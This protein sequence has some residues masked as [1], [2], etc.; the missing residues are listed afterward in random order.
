MRP[1][2]DS[3]QSTPGGSSPTPSRQSHRSRRPKHPASSTPIA[4][5]PLRGAPISSHSPPTPLTPPP[6]ITPIDEEPSDVAGPSNVSNRYMSPTDL[7]F[8][9]APDLGLPMSPPEERAE[10][11]PEE[12][13]AEATAS[14]LS[15][16]LSSRSRSRSASPGSAAGA[17]LFSIPRR[18][19]QP[20]TH[21]AKRLSN[22][23]TELIR[24]EEEGPPA[25]ELTIQVH[26]PTPESPSTPNPP[27]PNQRDIHLQALSTM[28]S[29]SSL[30]RRGTPAT[31]DTLE[32]DSDDTLGQET[33][34]RRDPPAYSPLDAYTYSEGVHIDLPAEVISAALEGGTLPDSAIGQTSNSRSDRRRNRRR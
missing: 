10:L 18:P 34:T 12:A 14:D 31:A 2:G 29:G 25:S 23:G 30:A 26:A 21:F 32:D 6:P 16:T 15:S 27:T 24:A 5:S 11:E 8:H 1:S 22:S 33:I 4:S 19:R 20:F 13:D 28:S 9:T 7:P 3:P 17:S